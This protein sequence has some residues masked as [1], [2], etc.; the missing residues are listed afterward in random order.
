MATKT[1]KKRS[2]PS[3]R[4]VV[5]TE[6]KSHREK[7]ETTAPKVSSE[8]WASV[9]DKK[10]YKEYVGREISKGITEFDTFDFA[11]KTKQNV[12]IEGPT[13]PGKTSAVMAFAA[14]ES[15]PFYAISSN[16]GI[17]PSQLFGKF[18]PTEDGKFQ[19]IDGPVTHLVRDGGVLLINEVNFIPERVATVLFQL[20]DK[21]REITLLDN[22]AE[23]VKAHDDLLIVADM[24]PDYEGTRPLNKAFR[25]RFAIQLW[26]GYDE[27]VESK[28]VHSKTLRDLATRVRDETAKGTYVT[29]TATNMLM[30][31]EKIA[32]GMGYEFAVQNFLA[33]YSS[34]E[35]DA[36][37][38]IFKASEMGIKR[39]LSELAEKPRILKKRGIEV[40]DNFKSVT[41]TKS[42]V[43]ADD[44]L[45]ADEEDFDYLFN[46]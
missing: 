11:L 21:R 42:E 9:P 23:V 7:T 3:R 41:E 16:V 25:N 45:A 33:H 26:W 29:P 38:M 36:L 24:N 5:D 14:K 22:Q 28:L 44:D 13:G 6:V 17:E 31:F 46:G 19:W 15:K 18:V 1:L 20:L 12:L 2:L 34:D 43:A 37:A 8:H 39:D 27:K 10:H 35:R 4:R 30:D 40:T 32:L